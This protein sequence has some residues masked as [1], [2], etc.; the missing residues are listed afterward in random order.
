MNNIRDAHPVSR[1]FTSTVNDL[2]VGQDELGNKVYR[3]PTGNQYTMAQINAQ[4]FDER[5]PSLLGTL[6]DVVQNLEI[7]TF[8]EALEKIP[9]FEQ[10]KQTAEG[11]VR[12]IPSA[13]IGGVEGA[14]EFRDK[15]MSGEANFYDMAHLTLATP[16]GAAAGTAPKGALRIFGGRNAKVSG[17][18][19]PENESA[20]RAMY[21]A[22]VQETVPDSEELKEYLS[23]ISRD[24]KL[25]H[26][27]DVY[28]HTGMFT[29]PDGRPRFVIDSSDAQLTNNVYEA[30]R[31][32]RN[33]PRD[34]VTLTLGEALQT[35]QLFEEYPQLRDVPVV[36]HNF[37]HTDFGGYW[38]GRQIVYNYIPD[39]HSNLT[40]GR[41]LAHEIQHAIQDIEGFD[42][43]ANVGVFS[44]Y[45]ARTIEDV[46][47]VDNFN[48]VLKS[49]RDSG[50]TIIDLYGPSELF[51][52]N[53][54]FYR[55][56]PEESR[57]FSVLQSALGPA[58]STVGIEL[59]PVIT[60]V[61]QFLADQANLADGLRRGLTAEQ[62]Y[63]R[64][65]GEVEARMADRQFTRKPYEFKPDTALERE[66]S[67]QRIRLPTG[68]EVLGKIP[69][70]RRPNALIG[71]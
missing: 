30:T 9:T 14:N 37:G 24:P 70:M 38:D 32:V 15:I 25:I 46:A 48:R 62:M 10:M 56:T 54:R 23:A 49:V 57:G 26:I 60:R 13:I 65:T 55:L 11:V 41:V 28:E 7:P 40:F 17:P 16:V 31:S 58:D 51:T 50:A 33:Q 45:N 18:K 43:G 2:M 6:N 27:D 69:M 39:E 34:R 3:T 64:V 44:P 67:W 68:E 42:T 61:E 22:R 1:P 8:Q 52:N 5:Y 21:A 19:V 66:A 4:E 47:S 63:F 59:G 53:N 20:L 35:R 29:M 36:I 12:S 71:E